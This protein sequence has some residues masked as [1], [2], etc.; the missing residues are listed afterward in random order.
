[1]LF[2]PHS[3]H[4]LRKPARRGLQ[5]H[6]SVLRELKVGSQSATFLL[7]GP[8]GAQC[9]QNIMPSPENKGRGYHSV[10]RPW[11][12]C[13]DFSPPSYPTSTPETLLMSATI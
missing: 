4:L 7:E 5:P 9:G 3:D 6:P 11:C 13:G 12:Q 8:R 1:M 10:P 2:T